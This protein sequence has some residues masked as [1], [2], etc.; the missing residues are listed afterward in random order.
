M[1]N[2]DERYFPKTEHKMY[3]LVKEGEVVVGAADKAIAEKWLFWQKENG[4]ENS[5]IIKTFDFENEVEDEE[6]FEGV[7]DLLEE[8]CIE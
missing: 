4:Y 2:I 3:S 7:E 6:D 8:L 5:T 1:S